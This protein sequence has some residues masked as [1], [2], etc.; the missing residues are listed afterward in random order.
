MWSNLHLTSK[1]TEASQGR[2]TCHKCHNK[3]QS[4]DLT[5]YQTHLLEH[6]GA[7]RLLSRVHVLDDS[8]ASPHA[9]EHVDLEKA[10]VRPCVAD[11][12]PH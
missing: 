12:A 6:L 8:V 10:Q 1:E 9:L 11:P 5:P 2:D 3:W 4:W 7:A